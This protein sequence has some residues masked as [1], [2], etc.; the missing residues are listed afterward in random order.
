MQT[1]ILSVDAPLALWYAFWGLAVAGLAAIGFVG[2]HRRKE[3]LLGWLSWILM[4][5]A[6]DLLARAG[7]RTPYAIWFGGLFL[8]LGRLAPICWAVFGFLALDR[9]FATHNGHL[10]I[11]RRLLRWW[12]SRSQR[13][14]DRQRV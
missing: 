3:D 12:D 14:E 4:W 2:H 7:L 5:A 11:P 9:F 13:W 10:D 8:T 6:I 1:I